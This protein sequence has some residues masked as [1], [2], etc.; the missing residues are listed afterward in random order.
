LFTYVSKKI[1]DRSNGIND[2]CG[3]DYIDD[4]NS[5]FVAH[6]AGVDDD[7]V[8]CLFFSW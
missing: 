2:D 3:G 8:D 7:I 1:S 6:N 5:L 4:S